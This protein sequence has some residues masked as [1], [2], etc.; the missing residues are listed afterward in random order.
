MHEAVPAIAALGVSSLVR[1]PDLQPWMV[2]RE[3]A[4]AAPLLLRADGCR[5]VPSTPEPTECVSSCA[6]HLDPPG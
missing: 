4:R 2:K 1:I 5:Q 3:R 6:R